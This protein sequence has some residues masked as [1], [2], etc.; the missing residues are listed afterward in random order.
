KV[1]YVVND[2]TRGGNFFFP[3]KLTTSVEGTPKLR[4]SRLSVNLK[5]QCIKEH[6][7]HEAH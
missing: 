3:S 1:K 4:E 6:K 2:L 7:P 5:I